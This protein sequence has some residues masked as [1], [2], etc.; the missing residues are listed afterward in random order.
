MPDRTYI[1]V[2]SCQQQK[3]ADLLH[4]GSYWLPQAFVDKARRY[5]QET[6]ACRF[7]LG[8]WLLLKGMQQLVTGSWGLHHLA[9]AKNVRHLTR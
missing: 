8:K 1:Y 9:V 2:A 6:D 7:L 5:E 3:L 4:R